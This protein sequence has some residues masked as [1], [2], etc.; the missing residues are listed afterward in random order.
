MAKINLRGFSSGLRGAL[1]LLPVKRRVFPA[2]N[3]GDRAVAVSLRTIPPA[4]DADLEP[5]Q[6]RGTDLVD[7]FQRVLQFFP[8]DEREDFRLAP[9]DAA[10]LA[11]QNI[12][13]RGI[14]P[15]LRQKKKRPRFRRRR[16]VKLAERRRAIRRRTLGR[17]R[18]NIRAEPAG[19][20]IIFAAAAINRFFERDELRQLRQQFRRAQA[21]V[22]FL[23]PGEKFG[24]NLG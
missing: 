16:I 15:V 2:R 5:H 4:I 18:Q 3:D 9:R 6:F 23:Q 14:R 22:D 10:R 24:G 17:V 13:P 19:V 11:F 20:V 1:Q 8:A 21:G 12:F 7:D